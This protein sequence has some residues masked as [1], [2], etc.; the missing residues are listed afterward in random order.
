MFFVE[1]HSDVN[2][3]ELK[4]CIAKTLKSQDHWGKNVPVAWTKLESVLR[5]LRERIKIFNFAN[6]LE[7]IQKKDDVQINTDSELLTALNFFHDTGVILFRDE[8]KEI[9]IIDVQWFVDAF[10]CIIMDEKHA[11]LMD[12]HNLNHFDDLNN[13]GLLF[14][15]LLEDLWKN[16]G[17]FEHKVSLVKHM[18]HL[19]MLAEL[20]RNT[21]YVPCMNKQKYTPDILENS[22][23]S[24]TL[25]FLFE[26]LPIVI[27]HR[28]I[29]ACINKR[30]MTLWKKKKK[31]CIYHTVAV[32]Q[33]E[34]MKH[35]VLIGIRDNKG[36]EIEQ[37]PY[38]IEIQ[39]ITTN[40]REPDK[41]LCTEI[42]ENICQ[43]LSDIMSTFPS[44]ESPYQVGYRCIIKP[45]NDQSDGSIVLERNM[46]TELEC[47]NCAPVHTVDVKSILDFWKVCMKFLVMFCKMPDAYVLSYYSFFVFLFLS[48]N[49]K[50]LVGCY[51]K[52]KLFVFF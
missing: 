37:Y 32:L 31:N 7:H 23:V 33:Y 43:I 24:S 10:K 52:L 2:M 3:K 20:D 9:I 4:M 14:N 35:R 5:K 18:K 50:I 30:N 40:P 17:F 47:S 39:A 27:F 48:N 11:T 8:I 25:C 6:L 34:K 15:S 49:W 36:N 38:S 16:E 12:Q 28:L 22:N 29:V 45:F 21:W 44:C 13:Y 42:K 26:F 19:D 46:H 1:K 51:F 41:L